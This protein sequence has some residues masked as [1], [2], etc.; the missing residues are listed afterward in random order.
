MVFDF[1][2]D[3][4]TVK[5]GNTGFIGYV[6]ALWTSF[7]FRD[8][9]SERFYTAIIIITIIIIII[10]SNNQRSGKAFDVT[11]LVSSAPAKIFASQ[12]P[13]HPMQPRL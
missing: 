9:A 1:Y 6:C 4:V 8:I 12:D 3:G 7:F 11:S 2:F 13:C 5:T 10:T